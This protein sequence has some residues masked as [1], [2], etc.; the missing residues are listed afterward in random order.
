MLHREP[1]GPGTGFKF[2]PN[3]FARLSGK[4]TY[5]SGSFAGKTATFRIDESRAGLTIPLLT[6]LPQAPAAG[7]LVF[8]VLTGAGTADSYVIH[9]SEIGLRQAALDGRDVLLSIP[10]R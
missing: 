4:I 6:E 3:Q 10:K 7:D 8:I 1:L 9:P 2:E 5:K